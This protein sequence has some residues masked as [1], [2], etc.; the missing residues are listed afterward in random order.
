MSVNP[1]KLANVDDWPYPKSVKTL[2]HYLGAA[3]YLRAHIPNFGTITAPLHSLTSSPNLRSEWSAKHSAALDQLKAALHSPLLL[4]HPDFSRP[5][6]V[7]TD[8]SGVG[9]GAVLHQKTDAG[10]RLYI[11]LQ[12][13]SLTPAERKYSADHK[14]LLEIVFALQKFRN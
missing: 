12:S 5:F 1:V 7:S 8:A 3:N 11:S 14:E 10:T 2:R 4:H 9:I 13:R 6:Y